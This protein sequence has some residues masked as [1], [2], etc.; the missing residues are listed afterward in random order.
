MGSCIY[1]Q[2]ISAK[3]CWADMT[4]KQDWIYMITTCNGFESCTQWLFL[5]LFGQLLYLMKM[6][7]VGVIWIYK[8]LL[9]VSHIWPN[10]SDV[11][12]NGKFFS[13]ILYA[14]KCTRYPR[15]TL[16]VVFLGIIAM[17]SWPYLNKHYLP[18]L[19]FILKNI[20]CLKILV[21]LCD[22]VSDF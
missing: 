13:S 15:I 5:I 8:I 1:P 10:Y 18:T 7:L 14:H 9:S 19:C 21:L 4:S 20:V 16:M 6:F 3:S 12:T 17:L 11:L 22:C 2:M